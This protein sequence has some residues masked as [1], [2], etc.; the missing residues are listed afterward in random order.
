MN[1]KYRNLSKNTV[2]FAVSNFGTKILTFLLVPL[3]TY[4]LTTREYGLVD[5]VTTTANLFIPIL[6]INVQDAVLRFAL[7]E[8]YE[9]AD[10]VSIALKINAMGCFL[11][12]VALI[13]LKGTGLIRID[14]PYVFFFFFYYSLG[15][16]TNSINHYL[17]AQDKVKVLMV[18]GIIV[19]LITCSLNV[20]LLL[21]LKWGVNGFL[22]ANVSGLLAGV[23]IQLFYGGIYRDIHLVKSKEIQK[24]MLLYSAPLIANSLAWWVNNASDRYIVTLFCGVAINGIYSVSYK[25]PTILSTIQSVFYNAWSI[26][27]IVDYDKRDSDGF[28]GN[29]YVLYS[30]ACILACSILIILNIPISRILYSKDF[31]L[32]WKYVPLLLVGAFFNGASLFLGCLFTA[33]KDSKTISKTT[34]IGATVN[35]VLNFVLVW[36]FGAIGAAIATLAGYIVT[37]LMRLYWSRTI[38]TMKVN[39]KRHYMCCVLLIFQAV[40]AT[41]NVGVLFELI[42]LVLIAVIQRNIY[43]KIFKRIIL[44]VRR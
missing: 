13:F 3:Y 5:L 32:A 21:I 10:I 30:T 1:K 8:K 24:E 43:R 28:I 42:V 17:K 23:L 19:T 20:T 2:L 39:W 25:I 12:S 18:S 41:I 15:A 16:I 29:T 33:V 4:V 40:L 31:F 35:T 6:T 22:I 37:W 14:L 9:P 26:S 36:K 34:I 11:V 27:A 7:D 44:M 38:I